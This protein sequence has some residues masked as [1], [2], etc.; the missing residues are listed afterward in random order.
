MN[1][2]ANLIEAWKVRQADKLEPSPLFGKWATNQGWKDGDFADRHA[3]L[4]LELATHEI[5]SGEIGGNNMGETVARYIH[6]AKPP[7]NWC[8]GFVWYCYL[9]AA[10]RLET[11]MPFKRSLGAKR[12]GESIAAVGRKFTDPREAKPGDVMV[13]HRGATGSWQGHI[14]MVERVAEA[15]SDA[16]GLAGFNVWTVEGNAGP[17]VMRRT[18]SIARDRFAF[19]ASLRR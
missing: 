12:L 4:A 14:A 17:K 3:L 8:A 13:F 6:P 11:E 2:F 5:G 15:N 1:L 7:A 16:M 10:M 9:Q 18:R 19:F